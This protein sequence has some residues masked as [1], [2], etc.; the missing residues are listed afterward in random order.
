MYL[1]IGKYLD[2]LLNNN[3][4]YNNY[5][6]LIFIKDSVNIINLIG[7]LNKY[8]VNVS[9][10][11]YNNYANNNINNNTNNN[12]LI[13]IPQNVIINEDILCFINNN[14]AYMF[15]NMYSPSYT[16]IINNYDAKYIYIP[17]NCKYVL[18]IWKIIICLL[19]YHNKHTYINTINEKIV[20]NFSRY[21]LKL[22][23]INGMINGTDYYLLTNNT[24]YLPKYLNNININV[25]NLLYKISP[26]NYKIL[27]N[28]TREI[29]L[30]IIDCINY[31]YLPYK[32][33][34][35][36]CINIS[37]LVSIIYNLYNNG[38]FKNIPNIVFI[39][40]IIK[41]VLQN[42]FTDIN[43]II[44]NLLVKIKVTNNFMIDMDTIMFI[45]KNNFIDIINLIFTK[46]IM[47]DYNYRD[48]SGNT[49]LHYCCVNK[50]YD[51]IRYIYGKSN[52]C[53]VNNNNTSPMDFA[54][55][56]ETIKKIFCINTICDYDNI[57]IKDIPLTNFY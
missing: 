20:M 2:I 40:Y 52:I 10:D 38:Y 28:Y 33:K 7:L 54:K 22:L 37:N 16:K 13:N 48:N 5:A 27:C 31:I 25:P 39:L 56:D 30:S 57:C 23:Y 24:T 35:M 42:G 19:I 44:D 18:H 14:D 3:M 12:Q 32:N 36:C 47:V 55:Y 15:D 11:N 29:Y 49:I 53:V 41:I 4:N 43:N 50:N 45:F 17:N 9:Y 51:L 34:T 21:L 6:S 26:Y 8:N 46:G 1:D